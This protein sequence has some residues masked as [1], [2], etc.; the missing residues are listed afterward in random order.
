[1]SRW[2]P[3]LGM[4]AKVHFMGSAWTQADAINIARRIEGIAP[5]FG[6]HVALTG[7]CLYKDGPRKDCDIVFYR[8]RQLPGDRAGLL[9][10]LPR[11]SI[12]VTAEHG[13]VVKAELDGLRSMDLFF[14]EHPAG[15]GADYV[16]GPTNP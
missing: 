12:K 4:N 2:T 7:G 13:W 6:Y 3:E 8:V 5:E 14:P 9:G 10:A 16:P 11:L 1:M 15:D